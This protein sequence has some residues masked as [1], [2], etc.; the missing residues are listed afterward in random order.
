[1]NKKICVEF[2]NFEL[3]ELINEKQLLIQELH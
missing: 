1:M 2:I 3:F